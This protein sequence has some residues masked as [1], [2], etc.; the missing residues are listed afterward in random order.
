MKTNE[1]RQQ[2][3]P[4]LSRSDLDYE[5]SGYQSRREEELYTL[6]DQ[7]NSEVIL[8]ILNRIIKMNCKELGYKSK[9]IRGNQ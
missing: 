9:H 4:S 2:F 6:L 7:T 8:S 3:T 1:S 5:N